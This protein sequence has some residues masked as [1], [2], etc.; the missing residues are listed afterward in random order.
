MVK[1]MQIHTKIESLRTLH[2]RVVGKVDQEPAKLLQNAVDPKDLTGHV[3]D[4]NKTPNGVEEPTQWLTGPYEAVETTPESVWL[5]DDV[6]AL[7]D[8]SE[9]W[10]TSIMACAPT[11]DLGTPP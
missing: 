7:S 2:A 3:G 5:G 8:L 9:E 1:L 10:Y 6:E 11:L 4:R